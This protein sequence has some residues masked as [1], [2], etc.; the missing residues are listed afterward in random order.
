MTNSSSSSTSITAVSN[1]TKS[2]CSICHN[3]ETRSE[4]KDCQNAQRWS[5]SKI[6]SQEIKLC[7]D[8]RLAYEANQRA[9][10]ALFDNPE[11]LS[12]SEDHDF[13]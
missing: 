6:L 1:M 13:L 8:R 3:L 4:I 10:E 9:F 11:Q 12:E 5:R 2:K 7:T